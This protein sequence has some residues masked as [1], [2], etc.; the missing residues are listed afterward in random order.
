MIETSNDAPTVPHYR[1]NPQEVSRAAA[2]LSGGAVLG[3]RFSAFEAHVPFLLQLKVGARMRAC[4]CV[5]MCMRV[6]VL[7]CACACACACAYRL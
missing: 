6:R 7:A 1:Y 3:R 2:L 4:V 5:C